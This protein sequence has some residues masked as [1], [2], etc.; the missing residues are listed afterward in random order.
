[1]RA[2]L[3]AFAALAMAAL[4]AAADE[5]EQA[6]TLTV[7][8]QAEISA[9]PDLAIV[10]LGATSE[11][12]SAAGALNANNVAMAG[13]IETLRAA[14]IEA[15]DIQTSGLTLSPRYVYPQRQ[16]S[17]DKPRLVGYLA[18]NQVTV[19]LRDLAGLGALLDKL[20]SAGATDIRG[21]V[22]DL[23]DRNRLLDDARRRAVEDARRKAALYAEAA[24]VRLGSL[25]SLSEESMPVMRPMAARNY[26]ATAPAAAPVPVETG[27]MTLEIR[28]RT[29][30][31]IMD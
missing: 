12:E 24:G 2:T 9:V 20:V 19:R 7:I 17:G 28:L 10:T 3:A 8:G 14:G 22:F 16:G 29:V 13:V 11:A 26:A 1:M 31:R 21:I 30:W 4:P 23:Q 6:R 15:R 18:S 27:E 25:S 5:P